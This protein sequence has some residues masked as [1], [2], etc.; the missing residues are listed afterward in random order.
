[1]V[2][3][4]AFAGPRRGGEDQYSVAHNVRFDVFNQLQRYHF[5][6]K[7]RSSFD[8]FEMFFEVKILHLLPASSVR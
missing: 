8:L 6:L 4:R 2:D 7:E 1:M 5:L 3:Y